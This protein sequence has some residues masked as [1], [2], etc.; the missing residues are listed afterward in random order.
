MRL[1]YA[2]RMQE[3]DE[4]EEILWRERRMDKIMNGINMLI[5]NGKF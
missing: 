4:K 1:M 2:L 3:K 5:Q